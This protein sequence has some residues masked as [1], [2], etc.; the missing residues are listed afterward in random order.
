[1][2]NKRANLRFFALLLAILFLGAQF[3]F[4]ADFTPGPT[5]THL[6]PVCSAAVSVIAASVPVIS[7]DPVVNRLESVTTTEYL[8][9][10][11]HPL[12]SPRAP[13]AL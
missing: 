11:F 1:M 7:L 9:F 4:C 5:G 10:V 8:P 2:Q 13:P 6:Y 3:H 12:V